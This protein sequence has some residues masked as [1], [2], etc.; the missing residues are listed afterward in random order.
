MCERCSH[1]Y[2]KAAKTGPCAVELFA[3]LRLEGSGR[4]PWPAMR[5][6]R[7]TCAARGMSGAELLFCAAST[8][9]ICHELATG[10]THV[11][12][13]LAARRHKASNFS[14]HT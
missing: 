1:N 6:A 7:R 11:R 13:E 9:H 5:P 12:A 2:F 3:R 4:A 10:R 14:R 8:Y